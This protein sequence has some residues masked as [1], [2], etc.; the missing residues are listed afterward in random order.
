[1]GELHLEIV[2]NRIITERNFQIKTSPPI[3]V[4]RESI[5]KDSPEVEGKSPN[6]HNKFYVKVKPLDETWKHI[7]KEG[8]LRDGRVKKNDSR[9][10]QELEKHGIPVK[11]ARKIRAVYNGNILTDQ[12]RGIV[13]IGEVQELINDAF[14]QV[15]KEGPI[16]KEPCTNM[17][18]EIMDCKLHEDAIHRGPAQV[19]PAVREGI[20]QAMNAAELTMYEPYQVLQIDATSDYMGAI[21]RLVQNK[22]GQLLDVTHEEDNL[23]VKS[24]MPVGEMFGFAAELRSATEGKGN[25]FILDQEFNKIPKDLQ[26]KI[27]SGIRQRKGLKDELNLS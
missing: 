23:L 7:I 12:T 13:H 25:F 18:I 22:R 3:V 16:A 19:Y 27:V 26:P 17:M 1:M 8:G 21:T 2:E 15:M 5:V 4:Y 6:K 9:V 24:K 14:E 11:E 10:Y 20:K